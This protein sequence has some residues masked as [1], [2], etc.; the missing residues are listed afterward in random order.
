MAL[1][2]YNIDKIKR[3]ANTDVVRKLLIKYF[4]DK[5]FDNSFD[6]QMYPAMIQD[7]PF[8]IPALAN[9]I[10]IVPFAKEIDAS[11]S[12]AV[13]GWNMFVL[14]NHRMYLGETYHNNLR[15]LAMQIR[16]GSIRIPEG[17]G[18]FAT[19]RKQTTPKRIIIFITRVLGDHENGYM[20]LNPSTSPIKA[21]GEP[22]AAR[23]TMM[24][25][26][27]QFFSRSGYGT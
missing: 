19:A 16:S 3:L 17:Y 7:L 5:G 1:D 9:K 8:I 21:P 25:M 2:S 20:D 14:G 15:D 24:G 26:P 18:T 6:R 27:Q 10:E 12:K 11:Q 13:L 23:Q 22:Y 4:V